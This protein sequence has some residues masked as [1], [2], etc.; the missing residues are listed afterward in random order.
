MNFNISDFN[1]SGEAI[2]EDIADKILKY[3]IVPLQR[4]RDALNIP[5]WASK[6]SGYRSYKWEKRQGRSGNSQHTFKGKGATD[7]TCQNFKEN[8]DILLQSVLELTDYTRIAIYDTFIHCD[9][10]ET[11]SGN[12]ELYSSTPD[13]KWKLIQNI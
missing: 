11:E 10:K 5:I 8:Q 9:Y 7:I 2:R 13:S 1:I 3:H 12:R 6:K 4:V